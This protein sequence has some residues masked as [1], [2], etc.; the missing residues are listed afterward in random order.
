[1]NLFTRKQLSLTASCACL[2]AAMAWGGTQA[3][4]DNFGWTT[5]SSST[6]SNDGAQTPGSATGSIGGITVTYS[7]QI[8]G[9]GG[10]SWG[11]STTYAGGIVGNAPPAGTGIVNEGGQSYTQTITFSS[12]VTDP[13]IS[14]WSLGGEAGITASFDF[15]SA[16]PFTI[17]A[18]GASAELGG[19]SITQSGNNVYGDESNGTIVFDGTFT[20]ITFTQPTYENWDEFT[21]GY[22]VTATTAPPPPPPGPAPEPS[23]LALLGTGVL[24]AAG[25]LRR[26]LFN[27]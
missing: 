4:A 15:T 27:R 16:E 26:R 12:A 14:F 2:L 13:A 17:V 21:V 24:G 20:S 7:G 25:L 8:S 18:G 9:L 19:S 22:D 10:P 1:M 23:S 3:R 6:S 11:P 5:W